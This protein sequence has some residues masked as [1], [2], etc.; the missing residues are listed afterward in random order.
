MVQPNVMDLI[1][2]DGRACRDRNRR[3]GNH[4]VDDRRSLSAGRSRLR[5]IPPP[6]AVIATRAQTRSVYSGAA[7]DKRRGD[8]GCRS[9]ETTDGELTTGRGVSTF[10]D[11]QRDFAGSSMITSSSH[12]S[13]AGSLPSSLSATTEHSTF[14]AG[15]RFDTA[16]VSRFRQRPEA[17]SGR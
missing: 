13:A 17:F 7:A 4:G 8:A 3:S 5:L 6:G 11:L 14:L 10:D 12:S 15:F 1:E 16:P 2:R 9:P